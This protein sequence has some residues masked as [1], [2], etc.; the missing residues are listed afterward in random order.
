MSLSGLVPDILG[1]LQVGQVVQRRRHFRMI[2]TQHVPAAQSPGSEKKFKFPRKHLIPTS[3]S[4]LRH[5]RTN[6]P[7]DPDWNQ[8][9]RV[10]ETPPGP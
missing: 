5:I 6:Q 2:L 9:A 1:L 3:L 8:P 10:R 4:T 7:L